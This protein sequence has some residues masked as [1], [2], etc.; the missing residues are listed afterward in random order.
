M[1]N[2]FGQNRQEPTLQPRLPACI[3]ESSDGFTLHNEWLLEK[4]QTALFCGAI[5]GYQP[6]SPRS[7]GALP[8]LIT[9]DRMSGRPLTQQVYEQTRSLILQGRLP[10]GTRLPSTRV[11]ATDLK[12]SRNTVLNAFD[13]LATEGYLLGAAG[14]G[15]RISHDLPDDLPP[16]RVV[17]AS[18]TLSARGRRRP[19]RRPASLAPLPLRHWRDAQQ[20]VR[21][22]RSGTGALDRFPVKDWMRLARRSS[23]D[24]T[25]LMGYGDVGG[26]R[27]LRLAIGCIG[28]LTL[29]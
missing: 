12:V 2:G 5:Q 20:T 29:T 15:T 19:S 28:K 4:S 26:H 27:P 16:I 9:L 8:V 7:A 1:S 3:T 24:L 21:P 25:K 17:T 10:A 13:Q 23:F 6:M 11:L 22:F 18:P 14:G